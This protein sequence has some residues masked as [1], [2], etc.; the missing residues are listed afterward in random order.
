MDMFTVVLEAKERVRWLT[1]HDAASSKQ[2]LNIRRISTYK[3]CIPNTHYP[4]Y[5]SNWKFE[6]AAIIRCHSLLERSQTTP[7][8][9]PPLVCPLITGEF[10]VWPPLVIHYQVL[11]FVQHHTVGLYCNFLKFNQLE[12]S[13]YDL[14]HVDLERGGQ[15]KHYRPPW[16][17]AI[18]KLRIP[19]NM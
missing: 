15:R 13:T 7:W 18:G 3:K 2:R 10:S 16:R 12:I 5:W 11:W 8:A 17:R 14:S 6:M 4:P 19:Q 9:A 1:Y